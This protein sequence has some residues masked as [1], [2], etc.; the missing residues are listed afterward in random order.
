M[1]ARVVAAA[2]FGGVWISGSR[3]SSSTESLHRSLRESLRFVVR[4]RQRIRRVHQDSFRGDSVQPERELFGIRLEVR[5]DLIHGAELL[6]Q[7][8]AQY[9]DCTRGRHNRA[10]RGVNGAISLV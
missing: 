8:R 9:R 2:P 7:A 5:H 3:A 10:G 6:V 4:A 1:P